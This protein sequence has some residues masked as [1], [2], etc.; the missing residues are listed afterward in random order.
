M[1]KD[2]IN[3]IL[4]RGAFYSFFT[5]GV[6]TGI[7]FFSQVL[8][9]RLL[10]S[11]EYGYFSYG[12]SWLYIITIFAQAGMPNAVM[13]LIPEYAVRQDWYRLKGVLKFSVLSVLFISFILALIG[14]LA[15]L[16]LKNKI[17]LQQ[18]Y[19]L[20]VIFFVL[21]F[22][23]V[24]RVLQANLAGFKHVAMAQIPEHI[25]RP[26]ILCLVTILIFIVYSD[27]TTGWQAMIANMVGIGFSML[28]AFLFLSRSIPSQIYEI[29][30]HYEK[31]KWLAI[32]F[33]M[34][35]MG[36]MNIVLT[37][38]PVIF[39]GLYRSPE[40]VALYSA[41]TRIS[42]LV[43]FALLAIN[44]IAAPLIAELFFSDK[45]DALNKMLKLIAQ[46]NF[47]LTGLTVL[48]LVVYGERVLNLFGL[49]FVSAYNALTVLLI[50]QIGNALAGPVGLLL[51]MTGHQN[52]SAKIML[53]SLI[54][55]IVACFGLIPR[56]GVMG[57]SV[58]SA[59]SVILWN[60]LMLGFVI[61]RLK[62]NPTILA[63][64]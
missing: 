49:E 2:K 38:S 47:T 51:N 35:L 8:L 44:A 12:L 18:I 13:R 3:Q 14:C 19:V 6:G 4:V 20:G 30:A 63:R 41:A 42:S 48:V 64:V 40:S 24:L 27:K 22:F 54:L 39:L 37:H 7:V 1:I 43:I 33:P 29:A 60:G 59:L 23:A 9:A 32:S 31:K 50:G 17:D 46:I 45:K 16:F 55:S 28:I 62:I 53:L 36:G 10:G 5:K 21:P 34:M 58:A 56:Y 11:K 25:A 26:L 52:S 15:L 57:A 61:K